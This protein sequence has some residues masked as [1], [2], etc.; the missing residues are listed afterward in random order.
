MATPCINDSCSITSNIDPVTRRLTM[1]A[2]LDALGGLEC[3][4]EADPNSGLR[5]R[6]NDCNL[7]LNAA[8]EVA[9]NDVLY[10]V[11]QTI[12]A[13]PVAIPGNGDEVEI[14]N[15]EIENPYDCVA[16]VQ[17]MGRFELFYKIDD[18]SGNAVMAGF[19]FITNVGGG[20]S[21]LNS[22]SAAVHMDI[23]GYVDAGNDNTAHR[24]WEYFT[25]H[26]RLGAGASTPIKMT[27][28][29]PSHYVNISESNGSG[30]VQALLFPFS[31][32]AT[33]SL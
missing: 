10:G 1:E 11:G 21:T 3:G 25:T 5:V 22:G 6:P 32:E 12:E 2:R 23:L 31:R 17:L 28:D 27:A 9:I 26:F 19:R 33:A 20:A 24:R 18:I 29:V 30:Y 15:L 14:L 13:S 16:L 7:N 4:T 8:G